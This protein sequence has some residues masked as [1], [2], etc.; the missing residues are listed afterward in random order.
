ML[1]KGEQKQ[2]GIATHRA[3]SG[4]AATYL[5]VREGPGLPCGSEPGGWHSRK[6]GEDG[7]KGAGARWEETPQAARPW[8]RFLPPISTVVPSEGILPPAEWLSTGLSLG[9]QVWWQIFALRL[10]ESG[11]VSRPVS[12]GVLFLLTRKMGEEKA[13]GGSVEI[14]TCKKIP[15]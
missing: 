11:R 6:M 12:G 5:P 4:N 8:P 2:Q 9:G 7:R 13:R 15:S 14:T 10:P 1:G 3:G